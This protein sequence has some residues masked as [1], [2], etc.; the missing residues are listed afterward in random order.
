MTT[1]IVEGTAVRG[2]PS[3]YD[4]INRV[5]MGG[6]DWR[7][8][9]SLDA[10][11]ALLYGGFGALATATDPVGVVWRDSEASRRALGRS[12]TVAYYRRKLEQPDVFD[13]ERFRRR[14]A[15]AE[16]GT[17]PTYFDIVLDVFAGHPEVD[18]VL[19]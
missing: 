11:D 3:F 14:L 4:E 6:E 12:E 17:G 16:S 1:F 9:D 5:F 15:E 10:L 7:L 13:Q 2:I 19:E 8:A 18:L